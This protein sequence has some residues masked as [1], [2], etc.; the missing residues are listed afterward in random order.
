MSSAPQ[1]AAGLAVS[2]GLYADAIVV[3]ASGAL[4]MSTAPILRA[5]LERIWDLPD[6]AVVIIDV[7]ELVF[8]DS[9]GLGELVRAGRR[10]RDKGARLILA[11]VDGQLARRLELTG[12]RRSFEVHADLAAALRAVRS[13]GRW[14]RPDDDRFSP[15]P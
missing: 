11:G 12:L 9:A 4:E 7:A 1:D 3:R 2:A 6:V 10:S 5:P 8:C 13:A 15:A 14:A